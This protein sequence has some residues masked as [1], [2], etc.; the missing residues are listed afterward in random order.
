[1]TRFSSR[2]C[3]DTGIEFFRSIKERAERPRETD[4]HHLRHRR[5]SSSTSNVQWRAS[6][7]LSNALPCRPWPLEGGDLG[8]GEQ[9][10]ILCHL[11]FERLEAVF[12]RGEIVALP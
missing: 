11:G 1:M 10:A 7:S 5:Q 6:D 2:R 12:H 3:R 4:K 8:F 9:N